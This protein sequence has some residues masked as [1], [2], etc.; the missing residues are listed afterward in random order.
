MRPNYDIDKI[1]FATDRQ[2]FERAVG[3]YES[4]KIKN[5]SLDQFGVS[6]TVLGTHP[7]SVHVSVPR[8]CQDTHPSTQFCWRSLRRSTIRKFGFSIRDGL[9][10]AWTRDIGTR[11]RSL[12]HFSPPFKTGR[13]MSNLRKLTQYLDSKF[14][15][16][17]LG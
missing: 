14:P 2:T 13:W 11:S 6:G 12:A 5:A 4:G 15:A 9:R 10:V 1:R 3:I 7:Y 17:A 8:L 16:P